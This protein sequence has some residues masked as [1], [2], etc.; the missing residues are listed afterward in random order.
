MIAEER[1]TSIAY[2]D[3]DRWVS[4][5]TC[6]RSDIAA[7]K[8]KLGKGVTL[9]GEGSHRDGTP[10]AYFQIPRELFSVSK[11]V[12]AVQALTLDQRVERSERMK[13]NRRPRLKAV[14]G[15]VG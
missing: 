12:K 7:L 14:Y 9:T 8:K 4:V 1:E 5:Y 15:E 10:Y 3:A 11:C 2:T 13:K 6:R